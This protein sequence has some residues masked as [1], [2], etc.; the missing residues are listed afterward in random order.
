MK[1]HLGWH[2]LFEMC[3][4]DNAHRWYAKENTPAARYIEEGHYRNP[5]RAWPKSH[6]NALMTQKFAKW[7]IEHYPGVAQK[8]NLI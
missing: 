3:E 8:H 2:D 7:L 6:S 5:S 4:Y 1:K